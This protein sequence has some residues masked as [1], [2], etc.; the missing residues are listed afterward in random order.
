MLVVVGEDLPAALEPGGLGEFWT[1]TGCPVLIADLRGMGTTAPGAKPGVLGGDVK[2]AFLSLHLSRPLLGQRVGDLLSVIAALAGDYPDGFFLTGEGPAG[3][4]ALHAAAFDPR[5]KS[6]T[7]HHAPASWSDVVRTPLARDQLSSAVPGAL[8]VYDL[9]D[10]ATTLAPRTLSLRA[11]VDAAGV[12]LSKEE[13][14]LAY[15]SCTKAYRAQDAEGLLTFMPGLPRPTRKP[16]LRAVDLAV[17][18]AQTVTL[19]DG[20][21]ATVKL[22]AVEEERD[23][24]RQAVRAAKVTIEVNGTP[25]VLS[26]GNY[27]LPVAAGGVQ[28]DCP[29]TG[30]YRINSIQDFWHLEKDARIRIWPAG[31][32]WID[33]ATFAY[34]VRQRWFAASTQMANEPVYVD[35]GEKP[36]AKKVYYHSGLDISGA[37][38]LVEVVSASDGIVLSAGTEQVPWPEN[39]PVSPGSDVVNVLDDQGWI[40][41]YEHL[42]SID[43]ELKPGR[44]VRMRQRIGVLGKEGGSGGWSHL[45]FEIRSRQPSGRW[46]TQEGYAFFWQAALREQKPDVLA[47]ARPHHLARTGER[48]MLDASKSWSRSGPIARFEWSFGEGTTATGPRVERSYDRPGSYCEVLKVS[49]GQ[50]HV[51]YDFA[52]V[53]V[54]DRSDPEMVPPTI[55]A[56][57]APTLG[58]KAGD[59]VTFKVRTFRTTDGHETWDFGDGTPAVD[60]QSDGNVD[61][62]AKVGYAVTTH[63]FAR[64]GHYL[65]GVSRTDRRGTSATARLHV[66]VE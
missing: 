28:V 8:A 43:P 25:V 59:S 2:E 57:Y 7:V 45:H 58:I 48:V 20:K 34:P 55:H 33:P 18:E 10:L 19:S 1:S 64:P 22:S 37:E 60:V 36:S 9:P 47:V 62:R 13:I 65:V 38:G 23:P 5:I 46:G 24:I 11:P 42:Q 30:G 14:A 56:A 51:D 61:Q 63:R 53:Q 50:G 54:L 15:A 49:D 27:Q 16:L 21:T 26:S 41:S 39:G 31:S 35:G 66:V 3:P 12:P 52:I 32:P 29:I 17:G 6:V 40:Y 4:I 44:R